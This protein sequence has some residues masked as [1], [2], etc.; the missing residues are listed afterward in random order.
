M[1]TSL[2]AEASTAYRESLNQTV[3]F[4]YDVHA[5]NFLYIFFYLTDCDRFSGAHE[6]IPG[7][8][9]KKSLRLLMSSARKSDDE[10]YRLYPACNLI[11]EGEK[12]FGFIEDTS[13]FHRALPPLKEERITLQIRYSG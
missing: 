2:V 6:M 1:H 13:C 3:M 5:L 11:I 12:G 8:H 10:I 7:S 4:H 9:R